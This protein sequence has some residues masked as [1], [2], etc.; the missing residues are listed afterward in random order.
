MFRVLAHRKIRNRATAGAT[1]RGCYGWRKIS[2]TTAHREFWFFES[3]NDKFLARNSKILCNFYSILMKSRCLSCTKKMK[4]PGNGLGIFLFEMNVELSFYINYFPVWIISQS[5]RFWKSRRFL[6]TWNFLIRPRK[7]LDA[8][9]VE[10]TGRLSASNTRRARI[11]CKAIS[12]G[13][14]IRA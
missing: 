9:G 13:R 11:Y 3:V 7:S 1:V 6:D 4:F 8:E 5:P 2:H 12:H 14:E 10:K